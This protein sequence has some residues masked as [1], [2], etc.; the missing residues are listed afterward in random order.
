[1][2]RTSVE[3]DGLGKRYEVGARSGATTLREHLAARMRSASRDERREV[4]ALRD[5]SFAV[6]EGE[7]IGVIGRNGAGK[8]TLLKVLARITVP[9]T[10]SARMRGRVGSLLEV[11]TGFHEELTGRE[12]IFLNGAILGMTRHEIRR[13]FDAIVDFSGVSRFLD[14]PIKRYSSGMKL[15]LAFAVAAHLEPEVIIVDEVL[16]V[17]DAEFQRRC[18]GRMSELHASGRTV[19]FVSHDLG[20][21]AQLCSRTL[22]ID[23]GRLHLDAPTDEVIAAYQH[24]FGT[25]EA[26]VGAGGAFGPVTLHSVRLVDADATPL[27]TVR[28]GD[29][30]GV[31]VAFSTERALA[32]LD[33]A[34][35]LVNARGMRVLDESLSDRPGLA[36]RIFGPGT[37]R[38]VLA[39]PPLL[40]S[41]E[42]AVSVWLGT[43][44]EEYVDR[45]MLRF[46]LEPRA[47]DR[48]E[49]IAR[50]RVLHGA[51]SWT[52]ERDE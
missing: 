22:W 32:G 29:P 52:V 19:L 15:R 20:A 18:L 23:G 6:G 30:F 13:Q 35:Y 44:Q 31:E 7:V 4:W 3:V 45:Q 46:D 26:G 8:S 24:S 2:Q 11:G 42:Y 14:T 50:P 1:M 47:E 43:T 41:G 10:G 21:V 48:R 51:G 17:G 27:K 5:V 16:A 33:L 49:H 36:E 28:R 25:S 9:T 40:A 39:V 12:N 37:Y 38:V 34:V